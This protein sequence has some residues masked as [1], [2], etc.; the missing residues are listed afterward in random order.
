M[1]M[2]AQNLTTRQPRNSQLQNIFRENFGLPSDVDRFKQ[3]FKF[4]LFNLL[5]Q[6]FSL[7]VKRTR[8]KLEAM[9]MLDL[10]NLENH[11]LAH[12]QFSSITHPCPTLC[13]PMNCSM[14]G[15]PV[16]HQLPELAQTQVHRCTLESSVRKI[17]KICSLQVHQLQAPK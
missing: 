11:L 14:P 4:V 5:N 16:H 13:D 3:F 15:S 2:K 9:T 8:M 17:T 6:D 7:L 12:L 10:V 1:A